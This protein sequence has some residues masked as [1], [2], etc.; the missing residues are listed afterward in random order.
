MTISIIQ[1]ID[2]LNAGGSERVSVNLANELA[3]KGYDV[4]LCTTRKGGP[5]QELLSP[6][7]K[8]LCLNRKSTVDVQAILLLLQYIKQNNIQIIHA[9]S[10][11]IFLASFIKFVYPG[12]KT[13]WHDHY[14]EINIKNRPLFSYKMI[15]KQIDAIITVNQ[16][17]AEW[18][19]QKLKIAKQKVWLIPNFIIVKSSHSAINLPGQ[20][21]F[22]IVCIAHLRPQKDHIT[23][24]RAMRLVVE[25]E[26]QAHLIL[27]GKDY[28]PE[29]ANR[30]WSE[31]E[32][33]NL[34]NHITWLG[35]RDDTQD[36]LESCDV[37]VLSSK[38]EGLPLSLL[39]YGLAGLPVVSTSVG[40]CATVLKNGELGYLVPPESPSDLASK[41]LSLLR[42]PNDREN[43]GQKFKSRVSCLYSVEAILPR[44]ESIYRQILGMNQSP[45]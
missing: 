36:I 8:Y 5:L 40:E 15:R 1:M 2:A 19:I 22:R 29:V 41:I 14:G 44:I 39:E 10:S 32:E 7:A 23:L 28:Y 37:G 20:K 42:N 31:I 30:I 21:G 18:S 34:T 35:P 6:K 13:V 17:L 9:H 3:D 24:V 26:P 16:S 43:L 33:L 11:S 4:T 38:S 45:S 12:V 27:V 25:S